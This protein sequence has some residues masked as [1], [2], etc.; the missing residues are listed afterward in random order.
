MSPSRF[1]CIFFAL[2]MGSSMSAFAQET[3][4][5][6]GASETPGAAQNSTSAATNEGAEETAP[7]IAEP[8]AANDE[9]DLNALIAEAAGSG[10]T[11]ASTTAQTR[12][13]YPFLEHHGYFRFRADLFSNGHL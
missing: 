13:T 8:A 2:L 1:S 3:G 4:A 10:D 7:E 12:P 6:S 9:V 5:E 11:S